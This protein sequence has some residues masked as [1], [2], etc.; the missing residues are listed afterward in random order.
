MKRITAVLTIILSAS[1][2]CLAHTGKD[3][4][5]NKFTVDAAT[6]V[7]YHFFKQ[8][9]KG[10]KATEGKIAVAVV[11]YRDNKD[12]LLFDSR[13]HKRPGDSI[14][15][16]QIPLKT[17]FRGCLEQGIE[18]MAVGDSAEFSVSADSVFIKLFRQ[19]TLPAYAHAGTFLTFDV[20]L[21][22]IKTKEDLEAEREQKIKQQQM[23][24]EKRKDEEAQAIAKYLADSNIKVQPTPDGLYVLSTQPGT[25]KKIEEGDSVA[26]KYRGSLL[27]GKVFDATDRHGPG[28]ETFKFVYSQH[29]S[30]IKGWI[31]AFANMREGD[32]VK[33]LIP[34]SIAYGARQ[35]GQDIL[36]YTPLIF[37]IEVVKVTPGKH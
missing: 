5:G 19:K 30:L 11:V 29:V 1:L 15:V 31:L 4:G 14:G 28:Q 13:I 27:N 23:E 17:T 36:P 35:M 7:K 2:S 20:K 21:V 24:A 18:L 8:D 25:G 9:K 12:S 22:A 34:S 37:D 16:V 3:K 32:K 10:V 33:L 26:V 6:G